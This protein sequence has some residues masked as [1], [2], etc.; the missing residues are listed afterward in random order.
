MLQTGITTA[1]KGLL[2]V[3]REATAALDKVAT[4]SDLA[5]A[6]RAFEQAKVNAL[7]RLQE[8]ATAVRTGLEQ[9]AKDADAVAQQLRVEVFGPAPKGSEATPAKLEEKPA[10]KP[11]PAPR[12][13]EALTEEKIEAPL[14][15]AQPVVS[16][17]AEPPAE[18]ATRKEEKAAQSAPTRRTGGARRGAA[19]NGHA[20]SD[21]LL[22]LT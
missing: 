20:P 19:A 6:L 18:G 9:F 7:A 15:P 22:P 17:K 11:T 10:P 4:G 16:P 1:E 12:N 3:I 8:K 2:D 13:R 5:E 21:G 14:A